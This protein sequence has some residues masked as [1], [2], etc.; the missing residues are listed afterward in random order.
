VL[1]EVFDQTTEGLSGAVKVHNE[2]HNLKPLSLLLR[3]RNQGIFGC[4]DI[5]HAR[6]YVKCMYIEARKLSP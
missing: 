5:Y 6:G 2:H 1:R 4:L 3:R